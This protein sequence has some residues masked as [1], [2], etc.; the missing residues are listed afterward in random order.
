MAAPGPATR[1]VVRVVKV[2]AG[3]SAGVVGWLVVIPVVQ[4]VGLRHLRNTHPELF[5]G[6][7]A[8]AAI[9]IALRDTYPNLSTTT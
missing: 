2:A 8:A 6:A 5:D 4:Y 1:R 3:L 9:A 7:A